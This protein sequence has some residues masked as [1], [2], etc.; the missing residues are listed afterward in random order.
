MDP[1][2]T[3]LLFYG[4]IWGG[5]YL[6]GRAL[7]AERFGFVLSPAYFMYKTTA[8]NRLI[9]S[10]AEKRRGFWRALWNAGIAVGVGLMVFA[11]Y[12]LG[13]NL[14]NFF[15]RV[16]AATSI[17]P[18]I[19]LPG[20]TIS[21][22]SFPYLIL[23]IS[24]V[25]ATHELAH[26]IATR[27]DNVPLKSAGVFIA[28]VLFG[29]F[30]EP[31]EEQLNRASNQTKLRVYAAGSF[32]NAAFG[33]VALLLFA[34]F[35]ATIS[36]FYTTNY[37]GVQV[38]GLMP[39]YPAEKAGIQAG[40]V[41]VGI[42]GMS[43]R[44]IADL[45]RAMMGISPGVQTTV[46]TLRGDFRVT[47]KPDPNNA[48]RGIMGISPLRDLITYSGRFPF[49]P[50]GLPYHLLR[51]EFWMSIVFLSVAVINMLPLYMFDGDRFLEAMLKALGVEQTKGI[52]TFA[53]SASLAILALNF[54]FSILR[55][56][57]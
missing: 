4:A 39:D 37:V 33:L 52:R 27:V 16:E 34:N 40:D 31:D 42:N 29:G 9:G 3:T 45:Q 55:F 2:I 49:L 22:E 14:F 38:A 57:F 28:V 19:P 15:Y 30:V 56:G 5:V 44:T 25:L 41:I 32:T 23:A 10:L 21:W 35:A 50:D 36:P 26:G 17:Q 43:V 6:A 47:T 1:T 7:K 18:V 51:V 24:L 8:L 13:L 11:V 46:S 48:S 54:A 53:T 20:L 12:M